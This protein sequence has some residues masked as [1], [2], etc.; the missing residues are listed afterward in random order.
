MDIL[1]LDMDLRWNRAWVA[2]FKDMPFK[3][4]AFAHYELGYDHVEA[5]LEI[6]RKVMTWRIHAE[7]RGDEVYLLM[8]SNLLSAEWS[9]LF[10][11]Y[12]KYMK[13]QETPPEGRIF[14]LCGPIE[15]FHVEPVEPEFVKLFRVTDYMH[16]R[17][18]R[19]PHPG[20]NRDNVPNSDQWDWQMA[21]VLAYLFSAGEYDIAYY[22]NRA[23]EVVF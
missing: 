11:Y 12:V 22:E 15:G 19:C 7:E 8:P 5:F 21:A 23:A 13:P 3:V 6:L 10:C 14:S 1:V 9:A 20:I 4:T 2:R 18:A 16:S 17:A